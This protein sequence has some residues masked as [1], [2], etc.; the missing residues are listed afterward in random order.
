MTA[1][2]MT[3]DDHGCVGRR[4]QHP[5]WR[6]LGG[7]RKKDRRAGDGMVGREPCR[8]RDGLFQG[9]EALWNDSTEGKSTLAGDE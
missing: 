2:G 6:R 1:R 4:P 5:K 8:S 3:G 7:T 9:A